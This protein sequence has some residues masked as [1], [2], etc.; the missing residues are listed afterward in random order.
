MDGR[1]A[2]RSP[3]ALSVNFMRAGSACRIAPLLTAERA[4]LS[5]QLLTVGEAS[6]ATNGDNDD[7][8]PRP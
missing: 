2:F 6:A 5:Q 3:A 4:N 1:T 7:R 8:A